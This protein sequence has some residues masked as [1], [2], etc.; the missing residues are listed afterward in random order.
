MDVAVAFDRGVTVHDTLRL[1]DLLIDTAQRAARPLMAELVVDDRS[2]MP[3]DFSVPVA[4]HGWVSTNPSGT[5]SS[6][7]WAPHSRTTSGTNGILV[8]RMNDN[9]A[10][11]SATWLAS[12]IIPASATTVTSVSR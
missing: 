6:G 5:C 4:G 2:G 8:P 9:P 7:C 11:C 10:A 12:E 3:R 1:G